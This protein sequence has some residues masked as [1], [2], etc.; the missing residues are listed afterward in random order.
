[1]NT[2]IRPTPNGLPHIGHAWVAWKNFEA[3]KGTGGTFTI[4][5]DD[6]TY[7]AQCLDLDSIDMDKSMLAWKE[8]L[9]WLF[10][11][12]ADDIFISSDYASRH[13]DACEFLGIKKPMQRGLMRFTGEAI[14]EA[15]VNSNPL[16]IAATHPSLVVARVVDDFRG[17]VTGFIRGNDLLPELQLY[18]YFCSRLGYRTVRQLYIPTVT[19]EVYKPGDKESK[20]NAAPSLFNLRDAGYTPDDIIGTLEELDSVRQKCN[21]AQIVVPRGVLEVERVSVFQS[22]VA[23]RDYAICVKNVAGLPHSG[24]VEKAAVKHVLEGTGL[25]WR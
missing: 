23:E 19:R 10:G 8:Q 18:D 14:H 22:Q 17:G 15:T 25:K 11:E 3:A 21:L 1:M 6:L 12:P 20:S 7:K 24:D 5:F 2:R 9:E 13:D 16:A 4:I